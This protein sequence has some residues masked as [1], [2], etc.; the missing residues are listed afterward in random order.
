MSAYER[1]SDFLDRA[2]EEL[3]DEEHQRA[4]EDEAWTELQ[5]RIDMGIISYEVAIRALY[6][7]RNPMPPPMHSDYSPELPDHSTPSREPS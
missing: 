5:E 1:L 7:L 3:R 6:S 2:C 4:L